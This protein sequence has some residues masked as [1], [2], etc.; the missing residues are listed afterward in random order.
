[1]VKYIAAEG[2]DKRRAT[3]TLLFEGCKQCDFDTELSTTTV[4]C[5]QAVRFLIAT[6]ELSSL[7]LAASLIFK[8]CS[9]WLTLLSDESSLNSRIRY[10]LVGIQNVVNVV[11]RM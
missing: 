5:W 1:M 4:I 6:L 10:D 9:C 7:C 3:H 11:F 2:L 8:L